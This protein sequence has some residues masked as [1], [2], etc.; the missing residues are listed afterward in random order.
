MWLSRRVSS[1]GE[2]VASAANPF[3]W[4]LPG[5][6]ASDSTLFFS[7]DR[8]LL[9]LSQHNNSQQ[10]IFVLKTGKEMI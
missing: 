5:Y 9:I 3:L 10:E 4:G 8:R 6:L 7:A 1:R 2:R